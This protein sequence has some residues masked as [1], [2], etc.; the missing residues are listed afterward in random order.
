MYR[1]VILIMIGGFIGCKD[2][3]FRE[4]PDA[5]ELAS[6]SS[7]NEAM[8]TVEAALEQYKQRNGDYPYVTETHLFDSLSKYFLAP[9]DQAHLYL[10]ERDRTNYIAIGNRRNKI[11]YRYPGT[12]GAGEYT[13]YWVGPNGVDEEGSGDDRFPM[14]KSGS[15]KFTRRILRKTT[16]NGVELEYILQVSGT[17]PR[18]DSM[19]FYISNG[20][21]RL[22]TDAWPVANYVRHRLDL[23]EHEQYEV[24]AQ[25]ISRFFASGHFISTD[26]LN[27]RGSTL[28]K[29]R[30]SGKWSPSRLKEIREVFIYSPSQNTSVIAFYDPRKI[31]IEK[32]IN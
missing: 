15:R 19:L 31:A 1:L 8:Q 32:V 4:L 7:A 29:L 24:I 12:V 2:V 27:N 10:N 22:Y 11:V 16:K 13:L 21:K 30:T 14:R 18:K 9:I 5:S 17:N 3:G 25:E 28:M 23:T 26:S 6:V 20:E